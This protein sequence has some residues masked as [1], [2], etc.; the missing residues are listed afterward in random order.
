MKKEENNITKDV[1]SFLLVTGGISLIL[2]NPAFLAPAILIAKYADKDFNKRKGSYSVSYLK[3][4]GMISISKNGRKTHVSLT[5]RGM[6]R[7]QLYQIELGLLTKKESFKKKKWDREWYIVAFDIMDSNRVKRDALRGLLKRSG[8]ILLQ[9]SMWVSPIDCRKEIEFVKSFFKI[10]DEECRVLVSRNIGD[11]K[12]LKKH[13][14]L[15]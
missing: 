4:K 2:T 3:K 12:K 10:N 8:F 11:D 7:A 13:F 1:L 5:K 9:K 14:K 15:T 6:K